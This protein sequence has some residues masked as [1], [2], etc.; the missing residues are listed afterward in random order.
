MIRKVNFYSLLKPICIMSWHSIYARTHPTIV[1]ATLE[2]HILATRCQSNF[3][4]EIKIEH[5]ERQ[6]AYS[7]VLGQ[8]QP[9]GGLEL[10]LGLACSTRKPE[11][12][13]QAWALISVSAWII[14]TC[15]LNEVLC[16]NMG[17]I[18]VHREGAQCHITWSHG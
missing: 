9:N 3:C 13:A 5:W 8:A 15:K 6:T 14:P 2:H 12:R 17:K 7:D 11:A 1:I 18:I 10:G 4:D 16:K